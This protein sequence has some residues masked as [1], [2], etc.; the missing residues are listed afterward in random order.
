[1]KVA[2]LDSIEEA[3]YG[4]MEEW[5][6]L[7]A[8]G[9]AD[10]GHEIVVSDDWAHGRVLGIRY[11]AETGLIAGAASPRLETGYCIGW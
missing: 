2:F 8:V 11:H 10:R 5:I 3:T 4:G 1:M 7:V 6:R 9:L